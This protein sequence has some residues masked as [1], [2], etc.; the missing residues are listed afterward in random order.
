MPW[1]KS[2]LPPKVTKAPLQV[3]LLVAHPEMFP[4][5]LVSHRLKSWLP[6][7][8]LPPPLLHLLSQLSRRL[9]SPLC[10]TSSRLRLRRF[11]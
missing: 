9:Q 5:R 1:T 8:V 7:K 10:P 6:L 11:P 4:R 3:S 2:S